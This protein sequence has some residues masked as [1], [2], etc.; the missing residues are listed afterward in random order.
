MKFV[1]GLTP[2]KVKGG[3][4]LGGGGTTPVFTRSVD[5]TLVSDFTEIKG[6]FLN[7]ETF[8]AKQYLS[9]NPS[10]KPS[11]LYKIREDQKE[12]FQQWTGLSWDRFLVMYKP[13]LLGD[14]RNSNV[15]LYFINEEAKIGDGQA[16]IYYEEYY[17]DEQGKNKTKIFLLASPKTK[18]RSEILDNI[19]PALKELVGNS[20]EDHKIAISAAPSET[21][22]IIH[23]EEMRIIYQALGVPANQI[24]ILTD[25]NEETSLNI[26]NNATIIDVSG[27]NQRVYERKMGA[28]PDVVQAA[29]DRVHYGLSAI[30]TTSASAASI[31]QN[32]IRLL[33]QFPVLM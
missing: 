33:Y 3:I 6:D 28:K 7:L 32:M 1:T 23:A 11:F 14:K 10:R 16:R 29:I 30:L 15:R 22:P 19:H 26:I 2:A 5:P 17:I 21:F 24:E 8:P 18:N 25:Q 20:P 13:E 27:G 9:F 31:G 4:Y 12:R